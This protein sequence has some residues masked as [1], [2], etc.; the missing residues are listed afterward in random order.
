MTTATANA[1]PSGEQSMDKPSTLPRPSEVVQA[2]Y[3]DGGVCGKN[4]SETGGTYAWCHVDAAGNILRTGCG[5]MVPEHLAVHARMFVN[6]RPPDRAMPSLISLAPVATVEEVGEVNWSPRWVTN[7]MTEFM[8]LLTA[9]EA[10][11]RGWSGMAC[12]DSEIT[13]GRFFLGWHLRNIEK[14]WA[15][16]C[17]QIVSILGTVTPVR[18]DGHPTL[19][20]LSDGIG[21]RGHL[22]SRHNVWCDRECTALAAGWNRY[23]VTLRQQG[24]IGDGG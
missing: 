17:R 13:I 16:R 6:G 22:V 5:L 20:E 7:N 12:S 11:P 1:G 4:P 14:A 10:L 15:D 23:L 2:V 3:A 18:L 9:L 19:K 8:G 21:H 24:V